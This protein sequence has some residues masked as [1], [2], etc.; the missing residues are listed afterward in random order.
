MGV[1]AA[2][3]DANKSRNNPSWFTHQ[4]ELG[5]GAELTAGVTGFLVDEQVS[6]TCTMFLSAQKYSCQDS[7]KRECTS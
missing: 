1:K 7:N 2:R 3:M 4:R 5:M 6:A